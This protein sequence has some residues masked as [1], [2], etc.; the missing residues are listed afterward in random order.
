MRRALRIGRGRES[1]RSRCRLHRS[2]C[3][4]LLTARGILAL[5]LFALASLGSPHA[6]T[7]RPQEFPMVQQ[8]SSTSAIP[9]G[10]KTVFPEDRFAFG[11]VLSG[12]VVEHDF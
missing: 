1:T 11:Q 6:R 12:A 8:D 9:S 2:A 5:A 3:V 10:S 7:R 4:V